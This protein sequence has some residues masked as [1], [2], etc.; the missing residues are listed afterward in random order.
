MHRRPRL[1]L[2]VTPAIVDR[3][4]AGTLALDAAY[5][6]ATDRKKAKEWLVRAVQFSFTLTGKP[7]RDAG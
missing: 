3:V 4:L 6:T 5:K 1:V 7:A 2:A